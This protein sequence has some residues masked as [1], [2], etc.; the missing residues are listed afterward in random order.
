MYPR[1]GSINPVTV[2]LTGP[3]SLEGTE[4]F[5]DCRS[6]EQKNIIVDIDVHDYRNSISTEEFYCR[7][8]CLTKYQ[9]HICH[10]K[11]ESEGTCLSK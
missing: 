2:A 6:V 10:L 8:T 1:F 4:D 7:S 3:P 11:Y 5:T 9:T